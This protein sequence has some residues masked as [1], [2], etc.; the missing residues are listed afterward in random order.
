MADVF[1]TPKSGEYSALIE[2]WFN[3]NSDFTDIKTWN[4]QL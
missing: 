4:F 3:F 1:T 2:Y